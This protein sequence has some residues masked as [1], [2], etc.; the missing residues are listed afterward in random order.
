MVR[1]LAGILDAKMSFAVSSLLIT[2]L[3]QTPTWIAQE[4]MMIAIAT[5]HL[6]KIHRIST[7]H[8]PTEAEHE[9]SRWRESIGEV[10]V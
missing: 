3:I 6:R 8:R 10:E 7:I 2:S 4:R 9:V 5:L 1:D